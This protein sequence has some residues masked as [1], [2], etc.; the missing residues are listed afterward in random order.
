MI[1]ETS[2]RSNQF[3]KLIRSVFIGFTRFVTAPVMATGNGPWVYFLLSAVSEI[4]YH[5]NIWFLQSFTYYFSKNH[6]ENVISFL[7]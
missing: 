6:F 4:K 3:R 5:F 1:P 7:I 2:G